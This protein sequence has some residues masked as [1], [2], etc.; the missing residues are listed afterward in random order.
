MFLAWGH[1]W[2]RVRSKTDAGEGF[3]TAANES[4][5]GSICSPTRWCFE[6]AHDDIWWIRVS[7]NG[8]QIIF[9]NRV[10]Q[11]QLQPPAEEEEVAGPEIEQWLIGDEES[12]AEAAGPV[13]PQD[14]VFDEET[15]LYALDEPQAQEQSEP[16]D[17]ASDGE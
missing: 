10:S 16:E 2:Y 5:S 1:T 8:P 17:Q 14:R 3:R 7:I 4:A 15:G 6:W 12:Q 13:C 11:R 9:T